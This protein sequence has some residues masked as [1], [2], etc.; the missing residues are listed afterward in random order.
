MGES[1]PPPTLQRPPGKD[2]DRA[3]A[4]AGE[5]K[6]VGDLPSLGHTETAQAAVLLCLC[7]KGIYLKCFI[8]MLRPEGTI[9]NYEEKLMPS[10]S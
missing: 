8:I 1:G 4:P 2:Q 3:P 9:L 10:A 7:P 5:R 6:G